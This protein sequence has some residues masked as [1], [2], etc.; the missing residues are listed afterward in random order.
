[1]IISIAFSSQDVSGSWG[2]PLEE[3]L[4]SENPVHLHKRNQS[5]FAVN[6]NGIDNKSSAWLEWNEDL[7]SEG[8]EGAVRG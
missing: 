7:I 3:G 5:R 1:M 4:E 6:R 2:A 8:G